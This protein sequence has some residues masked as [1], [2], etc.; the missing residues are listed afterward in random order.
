MSISTH[1][2]SILKNY[3]T[4]TRDKIKQS[5]STK[6]RFELL[7][8]HSLR[9]LLEGVEEDGDIHGY[10]EFL[11]MI[12][13][14]QIGENDFMLALQEGR[15]CVDLLK[16]RFSDLAHALISLDWLRRSDEVILEY[17]KFLIDL[18]SRDNKYTKFAV[19]KLV[20]N[21]V[22]IENDQFL[23]KR[24]IPQEPIRLVLTHIHETLTA[25]LDVIPLAQDM[26]L[27]AL[28]AAFPYIKKTFMVSGYI[29]NLFWITEYRP[30]IKEEI[31]K[32]IIQK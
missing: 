5:I 12:R 31:L 26:V 13:D 24:G 23:W 2:T 19:T 22:P 1:R 7:R 20:S 17:Q 16:P 18:L 3:A 11:Y 6:V 25:I 10:R 15:D 21:M 4:S 14:E 27:E 29:H 28:V 9:K 32:I 8:D 30:S